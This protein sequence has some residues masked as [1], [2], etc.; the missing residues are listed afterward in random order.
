M[1]CPWPNLWLLLL[2]AP[3]PAQHVSSADEKVRV[4]VDHT[5]ALISSFTLLGGPPIVV[6]GGWAVAGTMQVA[7]S[8]VAVTVEGKPGLRLRQ[9]SCLVEDMKFNRSCTSLQVA[10]TTTLLSEADMVSVTAEIEGGATDAHLCR[11]DARPGQTRRRRQ[12]QRD[13]MG[14]TEL[15]CMRCV[16]R[17]ETNPYKKSYSTLV[18]EKMKQTKTAKKTG[19]LRLY[20]P[21]C[22]AA[23]VARL[24]FHW[25]EN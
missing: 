5:S 22:K 1:K 23:G 8:V 7:S 9:L 6:S 3:A 25:R 18:I 11:E 4:T 15:T 17:G 20:C 10:V 2:C 21:I 14:A 12:I 24:H 16:G 13:G 19:G